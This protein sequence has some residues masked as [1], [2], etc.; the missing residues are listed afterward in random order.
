MSE[1]FTTR[2]RTEKNYTVADAVKFAGIR[3][4]GSSLCVSSLHGLDYTT[5]ITLERANSLADRVVNDTLLWNH[6]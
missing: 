1:V 5:P 6:L 3:L 2:E 4:G